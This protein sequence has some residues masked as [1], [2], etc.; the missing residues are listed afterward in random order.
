MPT[1]RTV[2]GAGG[3]GAVRHLREYDRPARTSIAAIRA[4]D[5]ALTKAGVERGNKEKRHNDLARAT[6]VMTEQGGA[7]ALALVQSKSRS[8][9]FPG[10]KPDLARSSFHFETSISICKARHRRWRSFFNAKC[11]STEASDLAMEGGEV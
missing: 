10:K 5:T 7:N 11:A 6:S 9:Q 4:T 2:G 1:L 3:I 8:G